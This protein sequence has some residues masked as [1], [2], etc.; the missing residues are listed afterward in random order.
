MLTGGLAG[1]PPETEI[2]RRESLS[3]SLLR[4]A[5]SDLDIWMPSPASLSIPAEDSFEL[6]L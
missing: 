3:M 4:G 6:G 2:P 1:D 5:S